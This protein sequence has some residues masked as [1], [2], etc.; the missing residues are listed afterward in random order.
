MYLH[1][2]DE[3]NKFENASYWIDALVN[4]LISFIPAIVTALLTAWVLNSAFKKSRQLGEGLVKVGIEKIEYS[5]GKM[6]KKDRNK[7][8]GLNGKE[9]P[10]ELSLCFLTGD[11]FFLDYYDY[12][13]DL[14]NNNC[15]IK[16]LIAS[17]FDS[18]GSENYRVKYPKNFSRE[19][20]LCSAEDKK[21]LAQKYYEY[22]SY[23]EQ[24]LLK[25]AYL[26]RTFLMVS[27]EILEKIAENKYGR[28]Y[29][30]LEESEKI[31]V[32]LDRIGKT[33]DHVMQAMIVTQ[34]VESLNKE[35][36]GSKIELFYYKD[37]Y[38]IPITI[39]TYRKDD[40]EEYLLWTNINAP[41]KET[42]K[43]VNVF[44]K[45]NDGKDATYITDVLKSFNYLYK[46]YST[47]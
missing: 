10:K 5:S 11:N 35:S 24:Q 22:N 43:S 40:R 20:S 47:K 13:L 2:L 32:W 46:K 29:A 14:L 9:K 27:Q 12:I 38:R 17:P 36:K 16:L 19:K 41:V 30:V 18:C 1:F 37:E 3:A 6:T 23:N 39:A 31:N 34:I 26:E 7:L 21:A 42:T 45:S 28:E 33:G 44:G 8:F 15:K 25:L 4:L